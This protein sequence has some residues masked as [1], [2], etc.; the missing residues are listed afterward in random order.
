[1]CRK[2]LLPALAI[3]GFG[4]GMVLSLLFNSLAVRLIVGV[5]AI[6]GGLWLLRGHC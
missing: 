2:N 4:A 6:C 1:M 5:A 3:L